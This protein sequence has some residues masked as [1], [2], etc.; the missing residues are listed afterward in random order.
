MDSC[1][2]C[3][4]LPWE[5][6]LMRS[7]STHRHH[8]VEISATPPR[9]NACYAPAS[10]FAT[11]TQQTFLPDSMR[12]RFSRKTLSI[13]PPNHL[14]NHPLAILVKVAANHHYSNHHLI[15]F[16]TPSKNAQRIHP[17]NRTQVQ[18]AREAPQ[19]RFPNQHRVLLQIS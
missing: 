12:N 2:G 8:Q 18:E 4:L 10:L 5:S 3:L 14:Q 9:H 6:T 13:R 19:Y 17:P 1:T 11:H 15:H 7:I 16:R